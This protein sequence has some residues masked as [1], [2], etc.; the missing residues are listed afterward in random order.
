[1]ESISIPIVAF[2]NVHV[3]ILVIDQK[4]YSDPLPEYGEQLP[5]RNEVSV[6]QEQAQQPQ[7]PI[8]LR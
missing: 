3:S 1:M 6:P 2:D 5:I 7:E 8:P 4:A